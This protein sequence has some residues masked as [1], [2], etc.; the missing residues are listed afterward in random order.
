M[1][2][3]IEVLK[4]WKLSYQKNIDNL[5]KESDKRNQIDIIED[6]E[7]DERDKI[8]EIKENELE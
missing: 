2:D 4:L 8:G 1:T 7:S 5:E 3:D 6:K